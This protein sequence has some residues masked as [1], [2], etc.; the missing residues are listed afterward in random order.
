[1]ELIQY[2]AH[3]VREWVKAALERKKKKY[4]Q[5]GKLKQR[6][7]EQ[8]VQGL[9]CRRRRWGVKKMTVAQLHTPTPRCVVRSLPFTVD[10][11]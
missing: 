10:L 8:A 7:P 6:L 2:G 3:G 4:I 11:R 1:M 9:E 5:L